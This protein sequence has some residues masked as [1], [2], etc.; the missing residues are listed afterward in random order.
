M[1]SQMNVDKPHLERSDSMHFLPRPACVLEFQEGP[2]SLA[3]LKAGSA[4]SNDG[5]PQTA[6]ITPETSKREQLWGNCLVKLKST[7]FRYFFACQTAIFF[8]G[9][10]SC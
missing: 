8:H 5:N 4:I 3:V 2:C 7:A 1:Y 10:V 6:D 9:G